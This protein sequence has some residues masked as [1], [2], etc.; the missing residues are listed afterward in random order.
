[1]GYKSIKSIKKIIDVLVSDG[2]IRMTNPD[3]PNSSKQKY[4]IKEKI[5]RFFDIQQTGEKR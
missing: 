1:M 2:K 5:V 3:K 4:V